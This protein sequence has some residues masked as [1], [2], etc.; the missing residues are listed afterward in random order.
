M[1]SAPL[2]KAVKIAGGQSSLAAKLGIRQSHVW[3][4]LRKSK[5][6]LP[7]EYVLSVER[8]TGVPRHQLRPDLYP[9]MD[10]VGP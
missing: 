1:D 8:I 9:Q 3:H 7:A 6:G 10:V 2:E 4:W 5:R